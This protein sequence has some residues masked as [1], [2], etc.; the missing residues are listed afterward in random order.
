MDKLLVS[1]NCLGESVF[2]NYLKEEYLMTQQMKYV[3]ACRAAPGFEGLDNYNKII[4]VLG[5]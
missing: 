2:Q 5:C 1:C 4:A 3:C